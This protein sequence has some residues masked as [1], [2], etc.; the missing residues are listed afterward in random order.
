MVGE[1]FK[2]KKLL[3]MSDEQLTKYAQKL[4]VPIDGI[5]FASGL[6]GRAALIERIERKIFNRLV[7]LLSVLGILLTFWAAITF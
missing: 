7:L 4:H 3:E 1:R 2:M 5:G 6:T